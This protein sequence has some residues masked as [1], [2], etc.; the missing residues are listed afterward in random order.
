M[1]FSAISVVTLFEADDDTN[2]S[3]D[4]GREPSPKTTTTATTHDCMLRCTLQNS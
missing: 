2:S 3:V 4:V 1:V